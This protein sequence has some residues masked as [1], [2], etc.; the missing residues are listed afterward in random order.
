MFQIITNPLEKF[1][2]G[3]DKSSKLHHSSEYN[4]LITVATSQP[5]PK[6]N[7]ASLV[8]SK[9]LTWMVDQ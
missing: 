5:E 4:V 9:F 3:H 8:D 1:K 6:W 2:Q 7:I